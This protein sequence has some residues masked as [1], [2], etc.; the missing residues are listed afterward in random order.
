M[1][2]ISDQLVAKM[3]GNEFSLQLGEATTSTSD[4]NACL[5]CYICFI[6]NTDNI[7][8]D[9][10]FSKPILTNCKAHELFTILNSFFLENNLEW[11]YCV[12]L[13]TDGA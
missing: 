12:G 11:K 8:E 13:C 2:D 3:C 5:I 4:E 10:L 9:L 1:D 6:D 7:V